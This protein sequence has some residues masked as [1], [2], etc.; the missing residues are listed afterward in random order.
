MDKHQPPP[1]PPGQRSHAASAGNAAHRRREFEE[2]LLA[3]KLAPLEQRAK[4]VI[5]LAA[6]PGLNLS[7]RRQL[8][9]AV[10]RYVLRSRGDAPANCG[11]LLQAVLT[12]ANRLDLRIKA[13]ALFHAAQEQLPQDR[14]TGELKEPLGELVRQ[15]VGRGTEAP[16]SAELVQRAVRKLTH[17]EHTEAVV[18]LC[19]LGLFFFA[20][21]GPLRQ[22]RAEALYA[23][24]RAGAAYK[25]YDNLVEQF[26][27]RLDYRLDRAEAAL[28]LGEYEDALDDLQHYL[29]HDDESYDALYKL[30]E[31]QI[32]MGRHIEALLTVGKLL[33]VAGEQ[34]R[35]LTLRAR[36]NEQLEFLDDALKDAERALELD[37][38]NQEA[39]QLRQGVLLRRQSYGMEDDLYTAFARGEEEVFLG[40]LKV[41]ETRFSDIGGLNK[42]KQLIRETIE[43]PL[44]YPEISQK[45][46]KAAGG[47][48]LFFGPPGCGKTM[49]ARAA[50]GEC[51]VTLINVNLS[52]ILDKWVGN[53]E[54]A[55]SMV[56]TAARKRAPSILFFDELDAI[57]GSRAT[58]QT[59][60]EKKLISQLLIELDGLSGINDSV[61]VLGA[62]N[63]PW[64][65]DFALRRAGRLGQLV[66]VPPPDAAGRAD[67]FSL[68]LAKRPMVEDGIDVEKLATLTQH[69]SPDA[70]RQIVSN[71]AAIP[72]REAI[73]GGEAR[74]IA[75]ADLL[76]AV[77]QTP[78]DLTEWE[79]LV[80]RYEEFAKQSLKH[81]GI[82]FKK[83]G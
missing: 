12:V 64:D 15:L 18:Q 50:A 59:G 81:A 1:T 65:V 55:I 23:L 35:L 2:R 20:F 73:E 46:G 39:R 40:D 13:L 27:D 56:F 29:R 21:N 78:P 33:E 52:Q 58:M 44:K 60:W 51:E 54:K 28:A 57:G 48:L 63:A 16:F 45:Y 70:I 53:S 22:A 71:A 68:Y 11:E 17:D 19:G 4:L 83:P 25:D 32:Q 8:L 66:F 61:L 82:G 80:S 77:E 5:E 76:A 69:H 72:W 79:K 6:E 43:Y 34:P 37:K 30:T 47:G 49:L 7:E 42:V 38:N 26:P 36:I 3:I 9:L 62:T 31:C 41:P 10:Q 74:P 67:V 14:V 75:M 24:G